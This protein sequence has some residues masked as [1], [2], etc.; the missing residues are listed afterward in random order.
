MPRASPS[1]LTPAGPWMVGQ[2]N[3]CQQA[4]SCSSMAHSDSVGTAVTPA[5]LVAVQLITTLTR[6]T[7]AVPLPLLTVQI[8]F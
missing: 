6:L 1:C 2:A 8:G 5:G 7:L 4:T 3:A